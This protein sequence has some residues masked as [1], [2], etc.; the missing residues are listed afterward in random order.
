VSSV[1][2]ACEDA[3]RRALGD[4]GLE[5][6]EVAGYVWV[7][8][9]GISELGEGASWLAKR[10]G[11]PPSAPFWPTGGSGALDA[12]NA[13]VLCG[14]GGPSPTGPGPTL[15]VAAELA[16]S[17]PDDP[18]LSRHPGLGDTD[19]AAAAAI[20]GSPPAKGA[21]ELFAWHRTLW[22]P[23][24]EEA[25]AATVAR[26]LGASVA[27]GC[28]RAGLNPE[29]LTHFLVHPGRKDALEAAEYSLSGAVGRRV[30]L[31]GSRRV[32]GAG[33]AG[34]ASVFTLVE[35]LRESR[36]PDGRLGV[37]SAAGAGSFE[38]AFFRYGALQGEP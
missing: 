34:G 38:H 19:G 11:L 18:I 26:R 24:P 10:L 25:W 21:H 23:D 29:D 14:P 4:A 9:A 33:D 28:R 27:D 17:V 3:A 16:A 13:L 6:G 37:I 35:D 31:P 5:P 8:T 22:R 20:G 1:L 32:L 12:L 36:V 2:A 30:S 7:T 15:L